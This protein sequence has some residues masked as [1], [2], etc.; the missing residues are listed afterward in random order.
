MVIAANVGAVAG[1]CGWVFGEAFRLGASVLDPGLAG[2]GAIL[3]HG[4]ARTAVRREHG[5]PSPDIFLPD[6]IVVNKGDPVTLRFYDK[7]RPRSAIPPRTFSDV[8]PSA[9][10]LNN[11]GDTQETL[12]RLAVTEHGQ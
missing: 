5:E 6:T 9:H 11:Q 3:L 8:I 2:P 1:F 4:R 7:P 10:G 12:R